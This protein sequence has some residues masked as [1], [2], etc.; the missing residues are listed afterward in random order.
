ML[1]AAVRSL[2][3]R[4]LSGRGYTIAAAALA[5]VVAGVGVA[6][7]WTASREEAHITSGELRAYPS[8]ALV[9]A[10]KRHV[11]TTATGDLFVVRADGTGLRRLK[12][13]PEQ[14]KDG[15]AYGTA[16]ARWSP[17]GKQIALMLGVWYG[18][19]YRQLARIS[20]DGR[21][22][23]TLKMPADVISVAW[24]SDWRALL[25]TYNGDELWTMPL[26]G[27]RPARIWR[28]ADV[29]VSGAE[30]SPDGLY[31]VAAT[32]HGIVSMTRA[33]RS[34]VPLTHESRDTEPRWS[35]DGRT[36]AFV[37]EPGCAGEF[38]CKHPAQVF[39]VGANGQG[40]RRL[41]PAATETA[42]LWSPD[43][44]SILFTTESADGL[45]TSVNVIGAEGQSPHELTSGRRDWPVAWFPDGSK[46]LFL[47]GAEATRGDGDEL[48]AMDADGGRQT[49]LPFN[50]ATWSVLTVDWAP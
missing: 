17:D 49:R 43:S 32:A 35:P 40:L 24:S 19:P 10:E 50:R 18:D 37:R 22:L 28:S 8:L 5:L 7:W 30:W 48:W 33:G 34:I 23:H 2:R 9:W 36:I 14:L 11:S 29:Q 41:T 20:S 13:W 25:T 21:L 44:R 15:H 42:L 1:P 3:D 16:A 38:E 27:G 39:V 31:V 12:A 46:I 4:R 45:I 6:I 47:R 26:E